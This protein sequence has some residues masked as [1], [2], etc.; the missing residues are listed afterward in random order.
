MKASFLPLVLLA[1][2][3]AEEPDAPPC[4]PQAEESP[5]NRA[6]ES[7]FVTS[8]AAFKPGSC[9]GFG[10]GELPGVLHGAPRGT[11]LTQ[12]SL[13]V[14]SLGSGGILELGFAPIE[15]VDGPGVDF[16]VFEN[17][18]FVG[19]DTKFPVADL[20]EVSV[21]EDG[22]TWTPFP[23]NAVAKTPVAPG[24][25]DY[26]P[27]PYDMC[28]GWH[29]V[30]ASPGS[31][32]SPLDPAL[33]GGDGFDLAAIGVTRAKFVRIRDLGGE[34]CSTNP[35]FASTAAGFDLDAIAVIHSEPSR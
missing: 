16:V 30:L 2:C 26:G 22:I 18:F 4:G 3:V 12:G 21:S 10:G 6:P 17:P 1:A 19:G 35:S 14:L 20:A 24:P 28:A 5:K 7:P 15:I 9:A 8:I 33:S 13:D 27:P 23:C 25:P 11:G 34:V 29:P 31:A 32:A